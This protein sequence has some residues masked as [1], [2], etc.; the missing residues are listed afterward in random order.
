MKLVIEF[1]GHMNA[2]CGPST[3]KRLFT[4]LL[5]AIRCCCLS[6]NFVRERRGAYINSL[7]PSKICVSPF[8]Y[9]YLF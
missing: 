5:V 6:H 4:M 7:V 9:S 1:M 8:E 2:V 3:C